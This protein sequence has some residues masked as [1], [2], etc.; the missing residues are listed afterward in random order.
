MFRNQMNN[1]QHSTP[2]ELGLDVDENYEFSSS[3]LK[4]S[5]T[6]LPTSRSE[7]GSYNNNNNMDQNQQSSAVLSGTDV[8]SP[9]P[10]SPILNAQQNQ[11]S[12]SNSYQS[13]GK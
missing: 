5:S 10:G 4:L 3:K 2:P 12:N 8:V 1:S 7:K 6:S 13:T 11:K 9:L